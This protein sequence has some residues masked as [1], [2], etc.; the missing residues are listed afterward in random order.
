MKPQLFILHHAG[1]N[2]YSYQF[3]MP[4]VTEHFDVI[5]TE[6]PGRGKRV[7]EPL[8][9]TRDEAM[10]DLAMLIKGKLNGQPYI[11]YGHSMGA[12]LTPGVVNML[13]RTG[14]PPVA[15][16]VTGCSTPVIP[17]GLVRHL[18]PQDELGLVLRDMGGVPDEF[19]HSPELVAFFE[20]IVRADFKIAE[21]ATAAE[22]I[23]VISSPIHNIMG[24]EEFFLDKVQ[25][26]QNFTTGEFTHEQ[27]EGAH[28]FIHNHPKE[29]GARIKQC[30]DRYLVHQNG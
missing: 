7:L 17:E 30:Y 24:T 13:T 2:C 10:L 23:P 21:T 29:L 11:T 27:M 5:A 28:F 4:F 15:C 1:G 8:I 16:I 18:L 3:L 12:M 6:L 22:D 20:P 25:E 19:F 26:W 9:T 14:A